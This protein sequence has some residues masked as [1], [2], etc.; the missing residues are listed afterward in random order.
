MP[1]FCHYCN[2]DVHINKALEI[3]LQ[4]E[5][6]NE[7][8]CIGK[9]ETP[10][11]VMYP[12]IFYIVLMWGELMRLLTPTTTITPPLRIKLR[13]SSGLPGCMGLISFSLAASGFTLICVRDYSE[14]RACFILEIELIAYL[15][16][17]FWGCDG[18]I[19][20]LWVILR[21]LLREC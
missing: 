8:A 10:L 21:A 19:N 2:W 3:R 9:N 5:S 15:W 6:R 17:Q 13:C 20:N 7:I 12:C 16:A 1:M 18:A 11:S 4:T 14:S